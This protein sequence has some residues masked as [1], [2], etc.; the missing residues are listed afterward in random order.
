MKSCVYWVLERLQSREPFSARGDDG[1]CVS[2][3][4]GCVVGMLTIGA[5]AGEDDMDTTY[6]TP[7]DWLLSDIGS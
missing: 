4:R 3:L 5:E 1:I 2:D 6:A 7:I